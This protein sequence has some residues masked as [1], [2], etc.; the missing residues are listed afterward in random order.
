MTLLIEK[1]DAENIKISELN[2]IETIKALMLENQ[3]NAP[4]LSKILNLSKG[5]ISKMFNYYKGLSKETIL[6]FL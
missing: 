3:Q 6:S 1:W 5:R 4:D 2:P